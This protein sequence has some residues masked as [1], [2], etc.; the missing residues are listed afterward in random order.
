VPLSITQCRHSSLAIASVEP[1][2]LLLR[3]IAS[4]IPS[5]RS[6]GD[7]LSE[8]PVRD[9]LIDEQPLLLLQADA[10]LTDV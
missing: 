6:G 7:R 2:T 4:K 5:K 10:E 9:V 8:A 3:S 1:E